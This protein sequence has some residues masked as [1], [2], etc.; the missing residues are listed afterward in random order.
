MRPSLI[1]PTSSRLTQRQPEAPSRARCAS[2]SRVSNTC[3][4]RPSLGGENE[5]NFLD[6]SDFCET[7]SA[8][9]QGGHETVF[10]GDPRRLHTSSRTVRD[11]GRDR[12]GL[13]QGLGALVRLRFGGENEPNFLDLSDCC[14]TSS[15]LA[16]GGHKTVSEGGLSRVHTTT[17]AGWH[18]GRDRSGPC[19]GLA[20]VVQ[21]GLGGENEPII[22]DISDCCETSSA[23][24]ARWSRTRFEAGPRGSW[25][26]THSAPLRGGDRSRQYRGLASSMRPGHNREN[27]PTFIDISDCSVTSSAAA[28]GGSRTRSKAGLECGHPPPTWRVGEAR[29]PGDRNSGPIESGGSPRSNVRVQS[30]AGHHAWGSVRWRRAGSVGAFLPA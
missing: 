25:A 29:C 20:S 15:A 26:V 9:A 11:P 2:R 4:G 19:L 13:D 16:Q 6:L 8:L 27:E 7:S 1:G 3:C 28:S 24:A 17:Q 10:E 22:Y 5:P 18:R 21:P 14:K 30:R 12:S 23:T